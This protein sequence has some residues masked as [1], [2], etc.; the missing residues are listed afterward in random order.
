[1][2]GGVI[3]KVFV[4]QVVDG[5]VQHKFRRYPVAAANV[6]LGIGLV[7]AQCLGG[8]IGGRVATVAFAA[9]FRTGPGAPLG[10]GFP[11]DAQVHGV[12]GCVGQGQAGAGTAFLLALG[13]GV[14]GAGAPLLVE[15]I[16]AIE[17]HTARDGAVD[18]D[19]LAKFR[20]PRPVAHVHATGLVGAG[21]PRAVGHRLARGDLVLELV[22]EQGYAPGKAAVLRIVK[23]NA[24]LGAAAGFGLQAR[25]TD[26]RQLPLAAKAV[27][28]RRELLHTRGFVAIAHAALDRPLRCQAPHPVHPGTDFAAKGAV[29]VIACAQ[30]KFEG[31]GQAPFVFGKQGFLR[32]VKL[33]RRHAIG[34]VGL[35]ILAA[36]GGQVVAPGHDQ[37]GIQ[38][39]AGGFQCA[40]GAGPRHT[41]GN[42]AANGFGGALHVAGVPHTKAVAPGVRQAP[43][44]TR[45]LLLRGVA[46]VAQCAQLAA[47]VVV[48]LAARFH[49]QNDVVLA[50]G[51]ER[52]AGAKGVDFGFHRVG[53]HGGHHP[54]AAIVHIGNVCGLAV[55]RAAAQGQAQQVLLNRAAQVELAAVGVAKGRF[56]L[57]AAIDGDGAAPGLAHFAGDDVDHP[58]HGIRAVQGGHGAANHF[59]ALDGRHRGN[60]AGL[61]AT[62][63]VRGHVAGR[64][65][66]ATINQNQRVIAGHTADADVGAAGFIGACAHV[67]A[68][69][70]FQRLRQIA[71][72][73]FLQLLA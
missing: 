35:P 36:K 66:A 28:A 3:H 70:I 49:V 34:H 38:H 47:C 51:C 23:V 53:A 64:V 6:E 63:V 52:Q 58:A 48:G 26:Q 31:V 73:L 30:R 17:L 65:L 41:G 44:V 60:K 5:P 12:L 15:G 8:C 4:E 62:K 16:A 29:A 22:V 24:Q 11:I 54:T 40:R 9:V 46:A 25:A 27:D 2:V 43:L 45:V 68:F 59:N 33:H 18:V 13:V 1:M 32:E 39:L 71:D 42:Q 20:N 56:F 37:F 14:V 67:H 69:H 50:V 72:A 10:A 57:Q 21:G 55:R 61:R 7:V 19:R